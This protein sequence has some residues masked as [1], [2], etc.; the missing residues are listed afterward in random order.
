LLN[1]NDTQK[2]GDLI[3]YIAAGVIV[4]LSFT[5]AFLTFS[6][7]VVR[8]IE[9]IGRNPLARHTIQVTLILNLILM[10]AT[11]IIGVIASVIIIKL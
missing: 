3:R 2:L 6:R 8:S 4:L 1:V 7:S 9:A 11:A 10:V 5:F